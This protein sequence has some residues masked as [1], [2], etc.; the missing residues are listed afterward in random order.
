LINANGLG[1]HFVNDIS[2]DTHY[3]YDVELENM[4]NSGVDYDMKNLYCRNGYNVL[5]DE[6]FDIPAGKILLNEGHIIV[7]NERVSG[8]VAFEKFTQ[9]TN[10]TP[11]F[12][13]D[14]WR[15]ETYVGG[16]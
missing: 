2:T 1:I 12:E 7:G 13:Y 10:E 15:S 8:I 4:D 14:V 6:T 11:T 3:I 5:D 16:V 9:V